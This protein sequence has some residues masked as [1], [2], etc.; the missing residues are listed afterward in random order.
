MNNDEIDKGLFTVVYDSPRLQPLDVYK[1]L[2][3]RIN[4]QEYIYEL[5][6]VTPFNDGIKICN[7]LIICNQ[8][9]FFTN[10]QLLRYFL[11]FKK[12]KKLI[13]HLTDDL[14]L[15]PEEF[16]CVESLH[17]SPLLID[18]ELTISRYYGL[19]IN[20]CL[21]SPPNQRLITVSNIEEQFQ[22]FIDEEYGDDERII[23]YKRAKT[24]AGILGTQD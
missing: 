20:G 17:N 12:Y 4:I 23:N 10:F 2:I 11:L 7:G 16:C 19:M 6:L 15:E 9:C 14:K 8:K 24:L 3:E 1:N 21:F 5:Y 13:K 18:E 22:A